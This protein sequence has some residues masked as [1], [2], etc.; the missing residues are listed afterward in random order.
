[1]APIIFY[2]L[3]RR[4]D[5]KKRNFDIRYTEYKHYLKTLDEITATTR[6]DFEKDFIATANKCFK[7]IIEK[8]ENSQNAL[9]ELNEK[10]S[11]LNSNIRE[12]FTKATNE[13]HGLRLVC[14]E[15][16]LNLIDEFVGIQKELIDLSMSVM[17]SFKSIDL[18][19]PT[20]HI[21]K[22]MK[23]KGEKAQGLYNTIIRQ[24]RLELGIK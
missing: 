21:P 9:I 16:L 11:V 15:K 5:I 19:N 24:M 2:L 20:A 6:I 8:P 10:M 13:L 7:E 17:S 4:D 23:E 3:K 12:S 1:M 22:D 14:S 18:D